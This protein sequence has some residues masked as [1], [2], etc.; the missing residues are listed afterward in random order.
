LLFV[1]AWQLALVLRSA[2]E[3]EAALAGVEAEAFA[4]EAAAVG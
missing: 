1:A 4:E 3:E 2:E